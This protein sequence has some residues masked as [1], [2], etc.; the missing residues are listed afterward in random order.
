M[1]F[2]DDSSADYESVFD[3]SGG[4]RLPE[5]LFAD[6][7]GTFVCF[8][9]ARA[10]ESRT[11][12][13]FARLAKEFGD[14]SV[15]WRCME[16]DADEYF[17][18]YFGKRAAFTIALES[19]SSNYEDLMMQWPSTN[20]ADT[21]ARR[22][23]AVGWMGNSKTW[24]CW[25]ERESGLCVLALRGAARVGRQLLALPDRFGPVWTVH[26]GRNSYSIS[27]A[28]AN[29]PMFREAFMA[30]YGGGERLTASNEVSD[31]WFYRQD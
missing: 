22:S 23:N 24:A 10:F 17:A 11:W 16:P 26:G 21:L 7:S 5:A 15:R 31:R 14:H 6:M 2:V 25:G 13:I 1:N 19:A 18:R 30:N 9:F 8:D 27:I 20:S 28:T 3:L 12:N 29:A 4:H